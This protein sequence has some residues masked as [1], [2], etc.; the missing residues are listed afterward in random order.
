MR[1]ASG[2]ADL[3]VALL[4]SGTPLGGPGGAGGCG[5]IGVAAGPESDVFTMMHEV[6]HAL[7]RMHAPCPAGITNIDP[8]YP[9][10][11]N[12]NTNRPPYPAG[13]I[14]EYGFN[15]S[16]NSV[17]SPQD[18]GDVMSGRC[19]PVWISPHTFVGMR[20]ATA[21]KSTLQSCERF[22]ADE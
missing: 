18:T 22:Y 7:G 15:L 13:T 20:N 12:P 19:R 10:H 2:T 1:T 3:Y 6:G 8:S 17:L 4:P 21:G 9:N 5:S 11:T 14:G 16:T